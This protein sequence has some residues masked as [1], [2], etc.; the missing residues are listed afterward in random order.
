MS[1]WR[2]A[3]WNANEEGYLKSMSELYKKF[4]ELLKLERK[5]KG[6]KLEELSDQLKISESS[7]E[8]IEEGE[9]G[10]LPSKIY[11]NLFARAYSEALGIDYDRTIEAIKE[12]IGE[13]IDKEEPEEEDVPDQKKAEKKAEKAKATEKAGENT[14]SIKKLLYLF[15]AIVVIFIAFLVIYLIFFSSQ[16]ADRSHTPTQTAPAETIEK[17]KPADDVGE[18]TDEYNWKAAGYEEPQVMT[19]R[20]IPRNQSWSTVLA[21]GDTAIFRNLIPGRVYNVEALYRMTVSIGIPSQ[22]DVEL[23]GN[24]VNLRDPET[25]RISRVQINQLNVE[26]FLSRQEEPPSTVQTTPTPERTEQEPSEQTTG[27]VILENQQPGDTVVDSIPG[28]ESNDEV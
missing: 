21:D 20:L 24:P 15:G 19:L 17:S 14:I 2:N 6:L 3:F 13:A 9:I 7:L 23:N 18:T 11:Y 4:G 1:A 22:V 25:G 26:E 12:D 28:S 16:N 10:S 5:R 27:D 8:H